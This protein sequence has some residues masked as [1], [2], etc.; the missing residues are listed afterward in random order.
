MNDQLLLEALTVIITVARRAFV[1]PKRATA[2]SA[3]IDGRRLHVR[4]VRQADILAAVVSASAL[5]ANGLARLTAQGIQRIGW[6]SSK[7]PKRRRSRERPKRIGEGKKE[8][9][10]RRRPSYLSLLRRAV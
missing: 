3:D 2:M 8:K 5:S 6:R 7:I 1:T 9:T 4:F 10:A